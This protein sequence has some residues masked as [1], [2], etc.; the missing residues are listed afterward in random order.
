[1]NGLVEAYYDVL[2]GLPFEASLP[3][4][5]V[6]GVDLLS[7]EYFDAAYGE[8]YPNLRPAESLVF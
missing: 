3:G 5:D 1:M 8:R 4:D 6:V 2:A 7:T